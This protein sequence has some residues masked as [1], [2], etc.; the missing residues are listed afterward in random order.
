[1][2]TERLREAKEF[3][4]EGAEIAQTVSLLLIKKLLLF[5]QK[6]TKNLKS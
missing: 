1:M 5:W 6:L 4:A 2:Q 3:R